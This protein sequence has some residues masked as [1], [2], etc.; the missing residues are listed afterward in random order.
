MLVRKL[1]DS[2]TVIFSAGTSVLAASKICITDV[3][4]DNER[5]KSFWD[6]CLSILKEH[7][8]QIM[9]AGRAT[10]VLEAVK[11]HLLSARSLPPGI[12]VGMQR[13]RT[14]VLDRAD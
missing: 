7:E 14:H 9:T 1:T 3:K 2:S 13:K 8:M 6:R 10:K 5:F 4:M 11:P 12:R